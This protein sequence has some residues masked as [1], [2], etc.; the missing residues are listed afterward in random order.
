MHKCWFGL[1]LAAVLFAASA[2]SRDP[3][4][5]TIHFEDGKTE[6]FADVVSVIFS[7]PDGGESIPQNVNEW[8]LVYDSETVSRSAPLV[9]LRSIEVVR[10]ETK[11]GYRCLFNAVLSIE[12]VSGVVLESPFKTLEWIRVKTGD[13]KDRTFYFASGDKIHIRKIVFRSK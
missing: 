11:S 3:I 1:T 5:G 10:Y 12:T 9:W 7:L 6:T 13:G 2:A 8:P 4:A